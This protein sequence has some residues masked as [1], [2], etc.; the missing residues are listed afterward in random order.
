MAHAFH[1]LRQPACKSKISPVCWLAFISASHFTGTSLACRPSSR[2]VASTHLQPSSKIAA[3][4]HVHHSRSCSQSWATR[5]KR[6]CVSLKK[7]ERLNE[8]IG[9][10]GLYNTTV[11]GPAS[12]MQSP[13]H[14]TWEH[15]PYMEKAMTSGHAVVYAFQL[16]TICLGH[17]RSCL[18]A[19]SAHSCTW[20]KT[21]CWPGPLCCRGH[22]TLSF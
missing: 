7:P 18:Q 9:L 21:F 16:K 5:Y 17:T 3:C 22:V 2:S 10:W 14:L 6:R 15:R 13:L 19:I 20:K 11:V 1:I 8:T 4:N 12:D